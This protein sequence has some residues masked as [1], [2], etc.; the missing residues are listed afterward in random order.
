MSNTAENPSPF[1]PLADMPPD[2]PRFI[3]R[4]RDP[5]APPAVTEW[6]RVHRSR[7]YSDLT[8]DK[9]SPK[10]REAKVQLAAAL[11]KA[12]NADELAM[13]MREYQ[14]SVARPREDR[15]SNG[16]EKTQEQLVELDRHRQRKVALEHLQEGRYHLN[17]AREAFLEMGLIT[18][19]QSEKIQGWLDRAQ[20]IAE[21]VD[22]ARDYHQPKLEIE[23]EKE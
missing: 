19:N 18:E 6:A 14:H 7:A 23:G 8:D 11:Q 10:S 22:P 9:G 21:Q 1:D 5:A 4:G 3:L 15:L 20:E 13:D 16:A 12:A 2:E 17:E